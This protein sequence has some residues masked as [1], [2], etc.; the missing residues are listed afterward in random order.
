MVVRIVRR[1]IRRAVAADKMACVNHTKI[2]RAGKSFW[3]PGMLV[4]PRSKDPQHF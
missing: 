1:R 2:L 4:I 3:M